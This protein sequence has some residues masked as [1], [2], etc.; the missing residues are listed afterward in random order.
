MM[1]SIILPNYNH[2]RFLRKRID[3][4]LGQTCQDFEL[5][6][7]DDHSTDNSREIILEYAAKD[8]RVSFNFN[9]VNSGNPFRQW[10]KGIGMATGDWIWIAE[11]DDFAELNLLEKLLEKLSANTE[12]GIAYCQSHFVDQDGK[13]TG[14]HLR[15][16]SEIDKE[17]W[18]TDFCLPGKEVLA[19][20]MIVLNIIPNAS[21]VVFRKSL[22]EKVDWTQIQSYKLSGDRLFWTMLLNQASICFVAESLNYFRMG[23]STVRSKHDTTP[24]YLFERLKIMLFI[25]DLVE[26]SSEVKL[27]CIRN[28][29]GHFRKIRRKNQY[30]ISTKVYWRVIIDLCRFDTGHFLRNMKLVFLDHFI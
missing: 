28:F 6:I 22:A 18:K 4:I 9:E 7:L 1:V 29:K 15:N 23:N 21:G 25:N 26:I 30:K 2:A 5:I 17:R 14:N 24:E 19:K 27:K 13:I 8:Q 12:A 20:Y 11:S 3:S 10:Q 16:L